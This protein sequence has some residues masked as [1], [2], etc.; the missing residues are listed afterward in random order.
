LR[1]RMNADRPCHQCK[2][3][4]D[5]TLKWSFLSEHDHSSGERLQV[6]HVGCNLLVASS[7]S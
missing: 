5:H 4:S 2:D 6:S 1:D 3:T 7:S